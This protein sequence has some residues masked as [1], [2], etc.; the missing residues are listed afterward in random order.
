MIGVTVQG[1]SANFSLRPLGPR[2]HKSP[3]TA[4]EALA[5]AA[6]AYKEGFLENPSGN[7]C[8]PREMTVGLERVLDAMRA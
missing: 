4:D 6:I 7:Q 5:L 2:F 3:V 8:S 1:I